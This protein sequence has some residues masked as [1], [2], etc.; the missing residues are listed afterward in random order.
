MIKG[1]YLISGGSDYGQMPYFTETGDIIIEI[2]GEQVAG[3]TSIDIEQ[4]LSRS[5]KH[6]FKILTGQQHGFPLELREYLSRRFVR[7]SLD[8][9]LQELIRDNIYS[10]TIPITTR[11]KRDNEIDGV[12]YRFVTKEQ[13]IQM[14]RSG[15]L[16]ESGVYCNYYYGTALPSSTTNYN[17]ENHLTK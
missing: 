17:Q 16:L 8:H 9:K 11:P 15:L 2:D 10:R 13:F 14:E 6:T 1:D 4:I 7:G 3:L 5:T 12:D